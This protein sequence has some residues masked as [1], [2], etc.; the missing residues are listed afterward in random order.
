MEDSVF[1]TVLLPIAL[2]VIMFSLGMSLTVDDFRRVVVY[3]RGISIGILNLAI[4]SPLLAFGIAELFDL[5]P[6]MAVGLVL[7]GASPGGTMANLL[8]HLARGDTAL[9][10]SITGISSVASAITVP[11]F[12]SLSIDH[13]G[14][15]G[16]EDDVSM[17]GVVARVLAITVVPLALGMRLRA[18]RP[19]RI[20]EIQPRF[21]RIAFILFLGIVV[22]VVIAENERVF[23][24]LD[25]VLAA[26]VALN[27]AAMAISF[28][29]A[30][31]ARLDDRQSTAIAIELGVHNTA[32]AI[33]V[34]AT[35][36]TELT[37]PAAVYASFMFVSAGLF[38]RL[39]YR[40]NDAE[41]P[42][43]AQS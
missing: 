35:I 25:A 33:A 12:L 10:I 4:L 14:A 6:A 7:L 42:A 24:N 32:L 26:A 43:G 11:L 22:G 18:R 40:R 15:V 28:T 37:I 31:L 20:A 41:A 3:P 21:Q 5:K 2:A 17:L 13:F 1:A 36:D 38:A 8:T 16:L 29:I 23:E 9:S 39:M 27:L 19:S 34:A 30:R